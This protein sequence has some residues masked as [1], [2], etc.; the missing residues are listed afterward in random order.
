MFKLIPPAPPVQVSAH[1]EKYPE[2]FSKLTKKCRYIFKALAHY[3]SNLNTNNPYHDNNGD[4]YFLLRIESKESISGGQL[5][6]F[7]D[8]D[9]P[10]LYNEVSII[11]EGYEN[12]LIVKNLFQKIENGN[13]SFFI[14]L[15]TKK[16][17]KSRE[18]S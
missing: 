4:L 8:L 2:Y 7:E 12:D 6:L 9:L 17:Y 10:D 16:S 11:P 5:N 3:D 13:D 15:N 14:T 1:L 18:K